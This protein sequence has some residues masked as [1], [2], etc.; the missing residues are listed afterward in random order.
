MI[1]VRL[2]Q[3]GMG[4]QDATIVR[5]LSQEGERVAKD[6]VL[7]E[8]EAAKALMEVLSP[9][10]GILRKILVPVDENVPVQTLLAMIDEETSGGATQGNAPSVGSPAELGATHA[11]FDRSSEDTPASPVAT[12]KIDPRAR[13]AAQELGV[14]LAKVSGSGPN[15]RIVEADVQHAAATPAH[16]R[17]FEEL[18]LS[19]TRRTIGARLQSSKQT[20]P[21]FRVS[22]DVEVDRLLLVREQINS[23]SVGVRV[24][25]ND[26]L[27]KACAM[28]LQE[29][30][31]MNIQFDGRSIKRFRHADVCVA[32]ALDDG[33]ITPMV[34]AADCKDVVAI[35]QEVRELIERAKSGVLKPEEFQGGTFTLSNLGMLGVKTFD[36]IIN[37][38]QAAILAVGASEPRPVVKNGELAIATVMNLCLSSDH[39]VID[40][41]VAA[42]FM[43]ALCEYIVEYPAFWNPQVR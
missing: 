2:A 9:A 14:D 4:M 42:R 13:R 7:V 3:Q 1:E 23:A 16:Q 20:A 41:A 6:A 10:S 32:V 22:R 15:G 37:P 38:P 11:A 17:E 40:G 36:A 34:T 8:I 28:A 12:V 21:H 24:S 27:V 33:L 25:I 31:A 30:P 39:R 29:V 19:P 18:R 43:A 5:W 35:A 26:L